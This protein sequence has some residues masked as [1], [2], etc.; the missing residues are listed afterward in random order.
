MSEVFHCEKALDVYG[1]L[2]KK[3][4]VA[5]CKDFDLKAS[6][7]WFE[8]INKRSGILNVLGHG[9]AAFSNKKEEEMF[10]K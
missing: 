5:N 8:K 3:T 7:G 4:L 2:V 6:R 10:K 9:E 1:D